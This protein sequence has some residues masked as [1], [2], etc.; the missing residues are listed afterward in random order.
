MKHFLLI[1]FGVPAICLASCSGMRRGSADSA[2]SAA[3]ADSLQTEE[4]L[5]V[6]PDTMYESAK[7]IKFDIE[8]ADSAP[9]EIADMRDMYRDTPGTFSFRKDSY[10]D[11]GFGGRVTGR[12]SKVS[13]VW[14]FETDEDYRDTGVGRWG[15]GSG[16]TGQPVIVEW[17]DSCQKKIR[18]AP[19]T[20][21]EFGPREVI[22]GS[23][24]SR[25]YF[26]NFD[27]GKASRREIDVQNPIKGSISLDPTLNGNLYCG[28]G[29]HAVR[30][31]GAFV[32]DV[33]SNKITDFTPEDR[34]ALRGWGAYDSSQ[35]RAGQFLFRVGENG[36][37]YKYLVEPGRVKLHTATGYTVNGRAPGMEASLSIYHNYGYVS[38]ND[39]SLICF[40]LNTM[41]PVWRYDT[42]DDT[43]C[44]PVICIEKG[45]P[46]VYTGSEI[47]KQG[48]GTARYAKLDALN[49]RPVWERRI[50][51]KRHD[52]D[53]K[54]FDGGFYATSLPGHG[55]C[56]NMIFNH[57]V[58]NT[59]NQNGELMAF[60]R[61]T[62]KTLWTTRLKRYAWSS[63]VGF[64]NEKEELFIVCFDCIGNVYLIEGKS[65]NI[66]Y[67]ATVGANFESSPAVNGNE[68]VVGSRGNKIM[69]FRVE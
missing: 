28:Q 45:H 14:T 43:D 63:P 24:A 21:P 51:G 16:W 35:I 47:D 13:V 52:T 20:L 62:G 39:G 31:F 49:G 2:D 17:P 7:A 30:P 25:V 41:K 60:D 19:G 26:I 9:S 68:L 11:A 65:G 3:I 23:L 38:D 66:M 27:S 10:R 56:K 44:S 5:E 42:G 33:Y 57:C 59:D 53:T 8:R 29:V 58:L 1:G 32:I 55:D 18:Q 6:L 22:V 34:K 50:E 46:Y 61:K 67:T 69:K 40:N 15:G 37:I 4:T 64:L 12:P 36:R 54:H 48:V